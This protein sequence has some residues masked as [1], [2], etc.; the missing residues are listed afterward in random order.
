MMNQN[1]KTSPKFFYDV[2]L[3]KFGKTHGSFREEMKRMDVFVKNLHFVKEHQAKFAA[4]KVSYNV[5]INEYADMTTEEFVGIMNGYKMSN[6]TSE[7]STFLAPSGV[8][9]PK[10]VDWSKKGYVTGIKNQGQ[11]GSCWSFSAT[12]SLEGQHFKKTGKLVSL[13]E[14]NLCDCSRSFGNNGCEGGLMDNAFKY[15]KSNKGIDTEKSYPYTAKDGS[16]HFKKQ[17]IGATDSG[18]VDITSGDENALKKAVATVGPI[19]VA[20]D[21]SHQSFQLY[22]EGIYNEPECSS[23][24]LDHGVLAVGYGSVDGK[25]YWLV[26]NSWGTV[27][28][29]K[30]YIKM[31]RNGNNQCGIASKASYPLVRIETLHTCDKIWKKKLFSYYL[32]AIITERSHIPDFVRTNTSLK[33]LKLA[34]VAAFVALAYANV[35]IDRT[36]LESWHN[37]KAKFGKSHGSFR[38]EMKRMDVFVSNLRFVKEHQAKFAAGKVSYNVAINEY[39][40]MTTQEFVGI[41]NGY[42][43]SNQTSEGSTFLPPSGVELPKTVDWTKKGYVTGIK[44]QGQCGSCWSFFGDRFSRRTTFQEKPESN[45]GCEGGLMDNAFKYIKSNKGVD[46]EK[47]Y[48]YTAKDGTCHFKKQ[49]IGATDS[50]FAAITSGDENALKKAV[51]TVG[52]ISIGIDASHQ[53]FQL[54]SEGVYNEPKCS[55]TRLDHGVLA[56]GYGSDNGKDYWL[57]KNS[58]GTGWGE[59]GYIK[60]TRNGNNQCGIA[61]KASYPLV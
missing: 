33:M 48:P 47:S 42:K 7:G 8:E 17:D 21:A 9:L 36:E 11:C 6:Q 1:R 53:S 40:D 30:G 46:T 35:P 19:S 20:I 39:A 15:I 10:T 16:C 49:D 31:T 23:T 13:S 4:G 60:M 24:A 12:G 41:M 32:Y 29:V 37:F 59:K 55:S 34:I 25:D 22:S 44:S 38:E 14:Q 61:S 28:G 51:A 3:A 50:G 2:E 5:A 27:W 52:P 54:Y 18:F 45:G 57:V 56:V 26:K 58:W 43:M